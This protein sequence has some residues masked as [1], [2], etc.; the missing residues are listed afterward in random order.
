[1]ASS[2]D[3]SLRKEGAQP[4]VNLHQLDN[5]LRELEFDSPAKKGATA[6][7]IHDMDALGLAPTFKR[8]FKFIAMVGFCSTVVVAWQ[9]TLTNFGFG[10]VDGGTGG[11][12]W[13]FIFGLAASTFLYLTLCELASSFPTA[14]GQYQWVAECAPR[15]ARNLLSYCTGWLLVLGWHTTV[16]GCG[17]IIGNLIKY[18]IVL[19]HPNN[20]AISSQWFPTLL[21]ILS[22]VL[23]GTF[24]LY[25]ESNSMCRP[26]LAIC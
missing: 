4:D 15:S 8:R 16:A 2:G 9:N 10:L 23:G 3:A 19:Y 13:T 24:N 26:Q 7:D 20:A 21:A 11:I 14:G 5:E 22:L 12:F 6:Y 25:C 17:V 1:M 18:C